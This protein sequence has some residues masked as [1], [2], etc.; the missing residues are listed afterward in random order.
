MTSGPICDMCRLGAHDHCRG[1][2][3]LMKQLSGGRGCGCDH[4]EPTGLDR[5]V[6]RDRFNVVLEVCDC[7]ARSTDSDAH[8]NHCRG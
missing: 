5:Q 7:C 6:R 1:N 3:Y 4:G 2:G 8:I